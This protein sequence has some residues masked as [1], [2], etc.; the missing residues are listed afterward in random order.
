MAKADAR[1][2]RSSASESKSLACSANG[3]RQ[4]D[5]A[6]RLSYFKIGS[7]HTVVE[8]NQNLRFHFL[9]V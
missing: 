6:E 8:R 9:L 5:R 4:L 2:Q 1:C 7:I 3:A